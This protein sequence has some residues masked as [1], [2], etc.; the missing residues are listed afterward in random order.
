MANDVDTSFE[1]HF[2]QELDEINQTV[3]DDAWLSEQ[4]DVSMDAFLESEME[5]LEPNILIGDLEA[6]PKQKRE[7]QFHVEQVMI[8]ALEEVSPAVPMSLRNV[9][10]LKDGR[11]L[12][13]KVAIRKNF[14]QAQSLKSAIQKHYKQ[15]VQFEAVDESLLEQ[16]SLDVQERVAVSDSNKLEQ[17][18][19]MAKEQFE[20]LVQFGY[21]NKATDMQMVLGANLVVNYRVDK[22]M[23]KS[24]KRVIGRE[25]GERIITQAINTNKGGGDVNYD[26]PQSLRFKVMVKEQNGS[27]KQIQLRA[28]KV[29]IEIDGEKQALGLFVRLVETDKP[30]TLEELGVD[31]PVRI[32]MK[33]AFNKPKGLILVTGPTSSGKTTLLGGAVHYFPKHL[34]GRT[35]EDPVELNIHGINENITQTSE[36]REMWD[37]YIQSMLRQ[38]P[39]MIMLGEVRSLSQAN[40]LLTAAQT[41]HLS[42]STM[43]TNDVVGI[44]TRLIDMGVDKKDLAIDGLLKL[45]VGTRLV[46]KT[47]QSCAL[48]FHELDEDKKQAV[49]KVFDERHFSAMRFVNSE[50]VPCESSETP[51]SCGCNAGIRGMLGVTEFVEPTPAMINRIREHGA[52]GLQKWLKDRGWKS[53]VDVG[54]FKVE[55]G[56][57]D[58]FFANIEVEGILDS[59]IDDPNFGEVYDNEYEHGPMQGVN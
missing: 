3:M 50:A 21:E 9:V 46:S 58:P 56:L 43:H 37:L 14:T 45:L 54:R 38:D 35:V 48:K 23:Q 57:I 26:T 17:T 40:T 59:V 34:T 32:A 27:D 55:K 30:K 16:F 22:V 52:E 20:T 13:S 33:R 41:G 44:I 1:Q 4:P 10:P 8:S 36:D 31:A 18:K 28:E 2:S 25:M 5:S 49:R 39:N 6:Q 12:I 53:M 11:I 15:Q 7:K 19:Y 29:P 24:M 51:T 47:C 42:V